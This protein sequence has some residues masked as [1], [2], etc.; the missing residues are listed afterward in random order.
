[1]IPLVDLKAQYET[2]KE[3]IA[4]AINEVLETTSFILGPAVSDFED[5]FA[6]YCGVA[7]CVGVGSGSDALKLILFSMVI[8]PGDEVIIPVNTFI[9]TAL[10]VSGVGAKVVLVD[11]EEQFFNIDVEKME[12]AITKRTKAI[13]PVHLFGQCANMKVIQEVADRHDLVVIEDACQ[14]HGAERNGVR[15]GAMGIAGAFSF[16]PGKNLGAY[17]DGGAIVTSDAVL[18]RKLHA[19]RNYGQTAK[20]HHVV[21]G[22]NSRLD[23]IQAAV[24]EVKLEHLEEW[25]EARR[26]RAS[27]YGE[28]LAGSKDIILP[29]IDEGNTHVW[30]LFVIR[31]PDRERILKYL[32]SK[33]IGAGIHYPIPIHLQSAYVDLELGVGSFPVAERLAEEML[34]LPLYPELSREDVKTVVEELLLA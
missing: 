10:A 33:G 17:G 21:R 20:Y 11:C 3:D 12:A 23:S 8:G 7:H 31:V 5:A 18:F 2:I 24:L 19:L 26:Q 30:H 27:W 28:E 15:S 29:E 1:M 34:S 9:A 16:Y 14:A 32:H 22:T 4:V 13:I 6:A 25:N